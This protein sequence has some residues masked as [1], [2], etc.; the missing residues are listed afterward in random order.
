[1]HLLRRIHTQT[2]IQMAHLTLY[3]SAQMLSNRKLAHQQM[4][5]HLQVSV[6]NSTLLTQVVMLV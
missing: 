6:C 2:S 1:M 3:M 4:L 5:Q